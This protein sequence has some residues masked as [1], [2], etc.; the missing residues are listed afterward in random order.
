LF[1]LAIVEFYEV[2]VAH[3]NEL[4]SG[5]PKYEIYTEKEGAWV[6]CPKCNGKGYYYGQYQK[7]ET[8]YN[9]K[10]DRQAIGYQTSIETGNIQCTCSKVANG[11]M[12]EVKKKAYEQSLRVVK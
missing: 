12:G 10:I 8:I 1:G 5:N 3:T 11:H 6:T 7:T 9:N 4:N 2:H